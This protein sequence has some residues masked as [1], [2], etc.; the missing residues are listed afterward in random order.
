[1]KSIGAGIIRLWYSVAR[2][3]AGLQAPARIMIWAEPRVST[4]Q[5]VLTLGKSKPERMY[6]F[7]AVH[8]VP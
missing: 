2:E 1:M 8:A 4:F 5:L 3:P 6:L 7:S